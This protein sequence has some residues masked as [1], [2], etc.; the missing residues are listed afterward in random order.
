[1]FGYEAYV[2]GNFDNSIIDNTENKTFLPAAKN[3][4]DRFEE[5]NSGLP[6]ITGKLAIKNNKIG[7]LGFSYMGGVYN[8]Y[9]DDG[10]QLDEKRRVDIVAVDFNTT[11]SSFR[12]FITAE[13]AWINVNVPKTFTQQYGS[14]QEGGFIDIVKKI[15]KK[16][17][18]GWESAALNI[19][20]RLEYVDWNVGKFTSTGQNISD[21]IWS[22]M[23]AVS[24]RP[25]SQSVLRLNYRYQQQKDILGNPA[26]KTGG[27]S[28]G[29]STYF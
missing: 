17:I 12:T 7:E 26:A 8:K 14:K 22:I 18:F 4:K 16:K 24:F 19:A 13:W 6:L 21:D 29:I 15:V 28:F 20:C 3:N 5:I 11:L 2:S 1:M 10:L 9:K 25:S 27:F 23:P